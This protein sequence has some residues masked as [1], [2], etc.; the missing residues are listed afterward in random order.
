MTH[1]F[2]ET[3]AE[4]NQSLQTEKSQARSEDL[5][6]I[7]RLF[8]SASSTRL[9]H[10]KNQDMLLLLKNRWPILSVSVS[11]SLG[12]DEENSVILVMTQTHRIP[13]KEI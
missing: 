9:T 12:W 1:I 7:L 13:G 6:A 10:K 11:V 8:L 2:I 4:K 5:Q 3:Q